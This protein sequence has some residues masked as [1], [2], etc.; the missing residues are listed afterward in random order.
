[1]LLAGRV[2]KETAVTTSSPDVLVEKHD[3]YA[4]RKALA[5]C[6]L[7]LAAVAW[8]GDVSTYHNDNARTGQNLEETAL[9]LSNVNSTAFGKVFTMPVDG[10]IDAE[11]LYLSS[12]SIQG[13]THNVVYAVTENDSVYAFDAD[14]GA[15]LWKVS[16][17]G[18]GETPSDTHSCSQITPEIGITA[19][20]VI[21]RKIGPHG[22]I[23]VVGMSKTSQ[24]YFQR[25]HALDMTTGQEQFGGPVTV[26]AKYPGNGDN[27]KNG[28]V[29]FDP[30]QYAERQGL[31]LVNGVIYTAWT[32]HCDERPYTGWVIG[33][34]AK[35]LKRT[36]VIDVVPNGS[37]GA[38][39]QAGAGM[40][41]D[42]DGN[43]FFLDGNGD[44]DTSL[45]AKGFP[46]MG[47]YG[48]AMVK[49]STTNRKLAV[50]DYFNMFNTVA[51][52]NSDEDFGSGGVL[53]LP[54]MTDASGKTRHLVLGAGKDQNIYIVNRKNMGKFDPHQNNIYQELDSALPGG[55][56]SMPAYFNGNV[57]FGPQGGRLL[58]F[59]FSQAKLSNTFVSRSATSF[60]YPGSTP[61]ISANGTSNGILWAIEH[62]GTSV[63]HAYDAGNL[64]TELYNSNQAAG[65][66]D[67][68]GS[69]SHFGTPMIANGRVYVGTTN[70]VAV[71][72]LIGQ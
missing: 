49:L 19:T 56:W 4:S 51:E 57:Y 65:S 17:L 28:F 8:A 12:V 54:P 46:V 32:S 38:I 47:D 71:F 41:A 31:T 20:P 43:L 34:N 23:Y 35:T 6:M 42:G 16:V 66:R 24:Q 45:D 22:T 58:Q 2:H 30:H 39:W 52:S 69:A 25:I 63:L 50:S 37:E 1:M 64:A 40:A 36:S 59:Q 11:P 7:L 53:L 68:F 33:Y 60:T 67:H 9:T 5:L 55:L 29:I 21:D 72:G 18:Q 3:S 61:S 48:N 14:N 62:A 13:G 15:Q 70:S 44:F 27:S 26:K 10:V